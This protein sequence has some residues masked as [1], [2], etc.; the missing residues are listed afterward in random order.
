MKLRGAL[1]LVA[2]AT[3]CALSGLISPHEAAASVDV[4]N[5]WPAKPTIASNGTAASVSGTF[6]VGAGVNRL[7]L[8][9]VAAECTTAPTVT[10]TYG[11]QSLG[12]AIVSNTAQANKIWLFKLDNA[13]IVAA[14]ANKTLSVSLTGAGTVTSIY[15]SASAYSGVNQTTPITGSNAASKAAAGTTLA[16]SIPLTANAGLT[17]NTG[18]TVYVANWDAQ[19]TSTPATGYSEVRDYQGANSSLAYCFKVTT[20]TTTEAPTSTGAA[21]VVAAAAGVSL[22]PVT[23]TGTNYQTVTTCGDCHGYPPQDGAYVTARNT[24]PG[25]FPGAHSKHSGTD[26]G[27]YALV[28][29]VCHKN[30]ATLNHTD[31]FKNITGSG[32]PRNT[33][34]GATNIPMTDTT[35]TETCT[36]STCHS[37]GRT[38]RQYAASPVWN[39]TTTCL[40]CHGGRSATNPYPASRSTSNFSMSTSH[41]QHLKYLSTEINCQMCH[42]KTAANHTTLKDYSGAM[43]H[44]NGSKNVIFNNLAY[45]SYTSYK[46]ATKKCANTACHGGM[47]RNAWSESAAINSNHTCAHCHG[48]AGTTTG[49][50]DRRAYAPGYRKTGTSTDQKTNKSDLRVGGHFVHLSSAYMK[51]IRC[52]E[53]HKVPSTPFSADTN[54]TLNNLRFNSGTLDFAQSSSARILIGVAS[55]SNPAQL[56]AFAGYTNGTATK[57]ATCSSV[58]CHGNRLKNGA[59]GGSYTK[60][61][62]NYSGMVTYSNPATA[63]G[64]CHGN[65]PTSVT[66]S[67]NGVTPTTGCGGCHGTVVNGSG[68]IIN[69]A[70][71]IDG[72]VQ[73]GGHAYPY[74][75][76]VHMPGGTGS[77]VANAA[78]PYTNCNG[79]HTNI[80]AGGGYPVT[81]GNAVLITCG[82]C[83]INYANFSGATPGCWDCHGSSASN[84]MPNGATFPNWSGSHQKHVVGQ[85]LA[86]TVCHD[87]KGGGV[88]DATHGSSNEVAHSAANPFVNVTSTSGQFHFTWT[89]GTGKG[90]CSNGTCHGTAEWGVTKLDCISC[91][92]AAVSIKTGPLTGGTRRAVANELKTSGTRNHKSTAVNNDATKFDCIVC[93]MEG[94]MSTGSSVAG[95]HANGVLDLRD[96]D[97]GNQIKKVQWTGT[98][99]AGKYSDTL[100]NFTTS[101]FSRNLGVVLEQDSKWLQVASIQK[102]LCLKCHD[103]NGA[104]NSSA[105]T[106]NAGGTTIGTALQPFGNA[107]ASTTTR[108]RVTATEWTPAGNTSG[109]VMNVFT[110]FSSGNAAYHPVLGK[111]NNGYVGGTNMKAPWNTATSPAKVYRTNTVYGWLV[112]CFDCHAAQGA[113]GAQNSTVV[114]HG[115]GTTATI[116]H[117]RQRSEFNQATVAAPNLC[118]ICHADAYATTANNHATGASGFNGGSSMNVTTMG[119]CKNCHGT[120]TDTLGARAVGAHGANVTEN[121]A[122]TYPTTSSRPYAFIRGTNWSTGAQYWGPGSCS[123]ACTTR[124]YSPGGVY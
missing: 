123:N 119:T 122:A 114:A 75:G 30:N 86:C 94:N 109:A 31:S 69:K 40:S 45:G 88:G 49:N 37:S 10:V 61:Y 44:G 20:G 27:Q 57:A 46:S 19:T 52:N 73:G 36:N 80:S 116:P 102:N 68:Q 105:W 23:N 62:W 112:S 107:A 64:R 21:A 115:N 92:T 2:A 111:A 93:H 42:G 85:S 1:L 50:T 29:T 74:G 99:A 117:M 60:P 11:G 6:T 113:T 35:Y 48:I 54:H 63:C 83:H 103:Y 32:V 72:R 59:A 55:A 120:Y 95:V 70:L 77:P 12:T 118:T 13:G 4:V 79:C 15:A 67:H 58:Y 24:P 25:Q 47:S 108:Y 9:A 38:T 98:G 65:P 8:V 89:G 124:T 28:C 84:G 41:S 71:H 18:L 22:N 26:E 66:A 82:N 78:A 43:Y 33:Y 90:T 39:G 104:N 91:H 81:R 34:G 17:G 16:L 100:T 97:T 101:R 110:Q 3:V 7:M 51:N 106:K 56:A 96:P 87:G 14:G 53:C 76:T 121:G 5:Q